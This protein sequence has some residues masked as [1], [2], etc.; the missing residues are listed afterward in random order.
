VELGHDTQHALATVVD[1]VNTAPDASG[2]ETLGDLAALR[3][4]VEQWELS[5][6]GALAD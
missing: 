3:R 1:L 6:V 4:F 2:D 5:E